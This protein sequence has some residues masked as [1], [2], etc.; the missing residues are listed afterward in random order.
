MFVCEQNW[1]SVDLL[2]QTQLPASF[3]RCCIVDIRL[4]TVTQVLFHSHQKYHK[5]AAWTDIS[6]YCYIIIINV[7]IIVTLSQK[8]CCRGTVQ[9]VMSKFSVNTVQQ[10]SL[11]KIFIL[12]FTRA[13]SEQGND[14]ECSWSWWEW[15]RV[16]LQDCSLTKV[17]PSL[18]WHYSTTRWSV[19][20]SCLTWPWDWSD[21]TALGGYAIMML[22]LHG[23]KLL[24]TAKLQ[25]ENTLVICLQIC[26]HIEVV[27]HNY[28]IH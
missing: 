18:S 7:M 4:L 10:I 12:L 26:I 9:N 1:G 16:L 24:L 17:I 5:I 3:H 14:R 25:W 20:A 2:L 19:E 8:K 27:L 21:A 22:M 15:S 6:F 28:E 13:L 11:C 23:I